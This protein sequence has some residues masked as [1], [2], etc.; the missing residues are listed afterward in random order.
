MIL[1]QTTAVSA[2]VLKI[3]HRFSEPFDA[4]L[5]P[6][7]INTIAFLAGQVAALDANGYVVRASH[8]NI[9]SER[10]I[11]LF[12][13]PITLESDL[14]NH[15]ARETGNASV[16]SR[17]I[18]WLSTQI[19]DATVAAGA[20]LYLGADGQISTNSQTGAADL[21]GYALSA[22]TVAGAP[23]RVMIQL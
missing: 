3:E 19:A 15:Y 23:V 2:D 10:T 8:A 11:G 12:A 9:A 16:F 21:I 4:P 13:L 14:K 20:P 7:T 1:N 17:G 22:R 6:A 5:N 18:V